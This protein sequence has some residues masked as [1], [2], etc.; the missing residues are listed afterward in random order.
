MDQ[1]RTQ[2]R[3]K[4]YASDPE[5]LQNLATPGPEPRGAR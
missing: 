3:A 4:A 5:V 1:F 2:M